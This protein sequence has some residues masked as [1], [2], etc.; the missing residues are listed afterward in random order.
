MVYASNRSDSLGSHE[1]RIYYEEVL[2]KNAPALYGDKLLDIWSSASQKYG[3]T[4]L[5]NQVVYPDETKMTHYDDAL[6]FDFVADC[7]KEMKE[8]ITQSI[9]SETLD[10]SVGSLFPL[11]VVNGYVDIHTT[12]ARHLQDMVNSF[13]QEVIKTGDTKGILKYKDFESKLIKHIQSQSTGFLF[14]KNHYYSSKHGSPMM[15]GLFIETSFSAH[16]ADREKLKLIVDNNFP[17]FVETA[18]RHGF[19]VDKNAPWRLVVDIRSCYV[20]NKLKARG[21]MNL[22]QFFDAYYTPS[23]ETEV[24]NITTFFQEMWN[25]FCQVEPFVDNLAST[26]SGMITTVHQRSKISNYSDI[27]RRNWAKSYIKVRAL[28][29]LGLD[30]PDYVIDLLSEVERFLERDDWQKKVGKHIET[31]LM[32]KKYKKSLTKASDIYTI[33]EQDCPDIVEPVEVEPEVCEISDDDIVLPEVSD[34]DEEMP[35]HIEDAITGRV[36]H[37]SQSTPISQDDV[38]ENERR[39]EIE[40]LGTPVG[41]NYDVL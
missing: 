31:Q 28:E 1:G 14:S 3:R 25:A 16:D 12:H 35:A 22:N 11:S 39:S 9:T 33:I 5:Y 13:L 27:T 6:V 36:R 19:F 15:S 32:R 20:R 24:S 29:S 7:L 8:Y 23:H 34:N 2:R 38:E 37:A 17:Y 4:D 26:D 21:I 40:G 41:N 30:S 18:R 10:P